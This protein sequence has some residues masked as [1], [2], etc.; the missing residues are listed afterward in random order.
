VAAF[1]LRSGALV[2]KIEWGNATHPALA[3]DLALLDDGTVYVTDSEGGGV[4]RIRPGRDIAEPLL[5]AGTLR[6][7]NGIAV[8]PDQRHL[9]VADADAVT[10]V[11]L[12]DL[13]RRPL[14]L[15]SKRH[16]LA[17]IDGMS[18]DRGALIAIQNDSGLP[19]VLRVA[20]DASFARATAIEVLES[21]NPLFDIP[22]TGTVSGHYWVYM[23]NPAVAGA[24]VTGAARQDLV[25]LRVALP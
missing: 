5:P 9:F 13:S 21:G 16:T 18:F 23:A 2:R 19:R 20:L 22:T 15:P 17:G 7:P 10:V 4:K 25:V 12:H 8:A 14:A 24:S 1:D 3:N 11:D 6:Y